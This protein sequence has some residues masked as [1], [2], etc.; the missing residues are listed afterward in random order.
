MNRVALETENTN[1]VSVNEPEMNDKAYQRLMRVL[2]DPTR[3]KILC[4][5]KQDAEMRV[6]QVVEEF[7][8]EPGTIVHHL[9]SLQAA[10]LIC[11]QKRERKKYY[12]LDPRLKE[13]LSLLI[14]TLQS[15]ISDPQSV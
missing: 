11:S 8:F 1:V 15:L 5:L 2:S 12:S 6:E 14:Q 4:L 3:R 9:Q 13:Q 10:G 7:L